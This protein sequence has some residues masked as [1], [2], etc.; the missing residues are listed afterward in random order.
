MESKI[1]VEILYK[2]L[3]RKLG[4]RISQTRYELNGQG[5]IP[6]RCRSFS[7]LHS[8]QSDPGADPASYPMCTGDDFL[9]GG[10]ETVGA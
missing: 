9:G 8:V 7:L 4:A 6:V 1:V 3:S 5:S 10:R 2:K